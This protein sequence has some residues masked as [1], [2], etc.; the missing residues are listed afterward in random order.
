[1]IINIRCTWPSAIINKT[2]YWPPLFSTIVI[3]ISIIGANEV[4]PA[5]IDYHPTK[6]LLTHEFKFEEKLG[7][8]FK[9]E[10][11]LG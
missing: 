9:F 7:H 6:S 5:K 2:W 3:A 1:V 11:K 4:G 10:E 8:E